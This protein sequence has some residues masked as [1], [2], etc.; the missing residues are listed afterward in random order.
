MIFLTEKASYYA[1][2][3]STL[4]YPYNML[5]KVWE[6]CVQIKTYLWKLHYFQTLCVPFLFS[7]MKN[8]NIIVQFLTMDWTNNKVG[9]VQ[10]QKLEFLILLYSTFNII[11]SDFWPLNFQ[12]CRVV[13][14]EPG[15]SL[16]VTDPSSS[17]T[18]AH[19]KL[20][21]NIRPKNAI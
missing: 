4:M 9:A 18:M 1:N 21:V 2:K 17:R 6:N 3:G 20:H 16:L 14:P 11:D 5:T 8:I 15:N 12:L 7:K 13:P 10:R 19:L